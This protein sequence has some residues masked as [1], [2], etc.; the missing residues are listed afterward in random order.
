MRKTW[1]WRAVDGGRLMTLPGISAMSAKNRA[2]MVLV[3]EE[4]WFGAGHEC[5]KNNSCL[6]T[7]SKRHSLIVH[8]KV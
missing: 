5:Y 1:T 4:A 8:Q 6:R 7:N 2:V 3:Q